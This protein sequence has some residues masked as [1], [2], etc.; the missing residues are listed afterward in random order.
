[1]APVL[2]H[3]GV[4]ALVHD[5]PAFHYAIPTWNSLG[6]DY[7]SE[8]AAL[9]KPWLA[10]YGAEDRVMPTDASVQV[11]TRSMAESGNDDYT[12][13]VLPRCGHAPVDTETRRRIRFENPI[14]N[15]LAG[16]GVLAASGT[17]QAR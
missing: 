4:A 10:I 9:D 17:R 15:W 5:N 6:V 13:A 3:C 12:V 2:A 14:L 1:M 11:I 7:E 16:H 8:L